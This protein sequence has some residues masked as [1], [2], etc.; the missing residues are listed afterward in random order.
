MEPIVLPAK[1]WYASNT[2]LL[3]L[4]AGIVLIIGQ[5]FPDA[6]AFLNQYLGSEAAIG[7]A[8]VNVLLRLITKQE[9]K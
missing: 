3:N 9:I 5:F 7:W 4:V 6:A 8:L 1:P 2:V